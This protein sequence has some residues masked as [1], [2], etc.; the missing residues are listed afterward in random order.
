MDNRIEND[1][2]ESFSVVKSYSNYSKLS[3]LICLEGGSTYFL[4]SRFRIYL[5]RSISADLT[6]SIFT[7]GACAEAYCFSPEEGRLSILTEGAACSSEE[8]FP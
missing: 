2:S 1:Q 8:L 3:Y 7:E 6:I 4:D 5:V